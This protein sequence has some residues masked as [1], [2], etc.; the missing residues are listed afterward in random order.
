MMSLSLLP[1]RSSSCP[2]WFQSQTL[3]PAK[4]VTW[5]WWT[6]DGNCFTVFH[7]LLQWKA[8]SRQNRRLNFVTECKHCSFIIVWSAT[9]NL[10]V[11]LFSE[12]HSTEGSCCHSLIIWTFTSV[13]HRTWMVEHRG[14]G[15]A[16]T[17]SVHTSPLAFGL[18]NQIENN[19]TSMTLL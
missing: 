5:Q 16:V 7:S 18:I 9:H 2:N 1:T 3:S 12:T 6:T 15:R 4:K 17:N 19:P 11:G 8:V 14:L 13:G 10:I